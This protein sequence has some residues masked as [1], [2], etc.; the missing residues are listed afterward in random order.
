MRKFWQCAVGGTNF[1]G[2]QFDNLPDARADA[3]K[4]ARMEC[5]K[6]HKI[7]VLEA[8]DCCE[9]EQPVKWGLDG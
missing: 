4:L 2:K 1:F 8:V 6:G 3:E 9:L 7:W 5:F